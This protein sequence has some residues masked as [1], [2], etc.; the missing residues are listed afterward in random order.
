MIS[1]RPAAAQEY[2]DQ[3]VDAVL[4]G[5]RH[6]L[7]CEKAR[8]LRPG[9]TAEGAYSVTFAKATDDDHCSRDLP[10]EDLVIVDGRFVDDITGQALKPEL[11]RAGRL[12]ELKG[13]ES[14]PVY[15]VITREEARRRGLNVL[16]TRWVDKQKGDEVRSR[17]CAQD[18]NF[19]KKGK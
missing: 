6:H 4:V 15:V 3:F 13:F 2:T 17:L 10:D 12:E 16:G 11:V 9:M 1:G 7:L 18:F 8:T 5:V 19:G 14:N